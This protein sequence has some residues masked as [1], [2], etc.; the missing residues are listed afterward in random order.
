ME[1]NENYGPVFGNQSL[2][3]RFNMREGYCS[4]NGGPTDLFDI[5]TDTKG[6]SILTGEGWK[7]APDSKEFGIEELEVF[8]FE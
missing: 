5:P 1:H 8:Y 2:A 3:I 7:R 4:T 6:N